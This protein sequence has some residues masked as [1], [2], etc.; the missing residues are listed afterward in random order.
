MLDRGV[1]TD[2]DGDVDEDDE[3]LVAEGVESFQVAYGFYSGDLAQV[4][5]TPGTQVSVAA[6]TAATAGTAA[7]QI[8]TTQFTGAAPPTGSTDTVYA[9]ASFYPYTFGPPPATERNTNHQ[10]NF[11]TV[12]VAVLA[13]SLQTDVQGAGLASRVLPILNQNAVPAWVSAYATA[14]GGHDGYERV[15][16]ETSVGLPNMSTRAMTYF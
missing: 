13:R 2:L 5:T 1:D 3:Q 6:G 15:V 7:N 11:Q 10:A 9:A 14:L 12:R 16:L 4:A 8:T